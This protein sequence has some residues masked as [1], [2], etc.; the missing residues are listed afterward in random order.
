MLRMRSSDSVR[1]ISL[2]RDEVLSSIRSVAARIRHEHP[3]VVSIR[4][5][6]S[7]AR[8]DHVGTSDADILVVLRSGTPGHPIDWIRAYYGYFR[9]PLPIDLLVYAENQITARLDSGDLQFNRLCDE[10]VL[11]A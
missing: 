2:N 11:L 5:F 3:E 4:L 9:L 8:G 6:G 1:T 7:I 10:S